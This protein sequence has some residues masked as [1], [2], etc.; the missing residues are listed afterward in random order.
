MK[1]C[2]ALSLL[3]YLEL[4]TS[5]EALTVSLRC[6]KIFEV[7][8]RLWTHGNTPKRWKNIPIHPI[9]PSPYNPIS[10]SHYLFFHRLQMGS[11]E[12]LTVSL[13]CVKIFELRVESGRIQQKD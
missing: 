1:R 7:R 6:V 5:I 13:R 2:G 9:T 8:S 3:L 12:A 4:K 11:I 10:P